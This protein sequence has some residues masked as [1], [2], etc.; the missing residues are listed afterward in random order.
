MTVKELIEKL[1]TYDEN[2]QV[3]IAYF[4]AYAEGQIGNAGIVHREVVVGTSLKVPGTI[5][6][7]A[8]NIRNI[9]D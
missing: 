8:G 7:G 9:L 2:Q 1:K 4:D 6:V 5:L 3:E